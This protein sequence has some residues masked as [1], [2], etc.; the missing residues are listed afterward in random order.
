MA[1]NNYSHF[2]DNKLTPVRKS[3]VSSRTGYSKSIHVNSE[4]KDGVER[5]VGKKSNKKGEETITENVSKV[6][7]K[8]F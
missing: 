5:I 7:Y 4:E 6:L 1:H 2:Q 8:T 3:Q